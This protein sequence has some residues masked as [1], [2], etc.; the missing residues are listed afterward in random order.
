M[1]ET[2]TTPSATLPSVFGAIADAIRMVD[3]LNATFTPAEMPDYILSLPKPYTRMT[4]LAKTGYRTAGIY[5]AE[6]NNTNTVSRLHIS[7]DQVNVKNMQ[8]SM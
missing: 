7:E 3:G 4:V 5:S 6:R 2:A 8:S 1:L